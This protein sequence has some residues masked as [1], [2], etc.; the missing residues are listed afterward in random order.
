MSKCLLFLKSFNSSLISH[1]RQTCPDSTLRLVYLQMRCLSVSRRCSH[2]AQHTLIRIPCWFVVN[3]ASMLFELSTI[4]LILNHSVEPA[5]PI[6]IEK[7]FINTA[8]VDNFVHLINMQ[9]IL[10]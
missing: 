10:Q 1:L 7:V 6:L 9:F 3:L 2:D 8:D 5:E 4:S